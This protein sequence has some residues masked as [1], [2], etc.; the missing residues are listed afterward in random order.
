MA[1]QQSSISLGHLLMQGL[2]NP[3]DTVVI[4]AY[5]AG[6]RWTCSL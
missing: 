3:F 6:T 1:L 4:A 5:A 2:I